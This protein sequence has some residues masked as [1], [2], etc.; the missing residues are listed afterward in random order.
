VTTSRSAR[1]AASKSP[2]ETQALAHSLSNSG[3]DAA[4]LNATADEPIPRNDASQVLRRSE[5]LLDQQ[6]RT[7]HERLSRLEVMTPLYDNF[8]GTLTEM[9]NCVGRQIEDTVLALRRT[10]YLLAQVN[11]AC[12]EGCGLLP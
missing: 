2:D 7:S 6:R 4:K 11:A 12:Q 10:E 3:L 9:L 1:R 8:A 5:I